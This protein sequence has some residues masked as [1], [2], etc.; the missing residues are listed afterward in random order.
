LA[1]DPSGFLS[2]EQD[3][4]TAI[5]VENLEAFPVDVN[6]ASREQLL[7]V[8]GVGPTSAQR[9]LENRRQHKIDT[10]HDLQAMGVVRTRAWPFLA[11]P[12]QRPPPGKQL[13]LELFGEAAREKQRR[14]LQPAAASAATSPAPASPAG[15]G[16][17]SAPCGAGGSCL[18]CSMY[19]VPGH[20]GSE[21]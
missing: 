20:P 17:A 21:R 11:F 14:Q 18:G 12:G 19:G 2:L 6:A 10:W 9:I 7:R 13:R 5:A 4:K 16:P 1:F 8:P 3:P 15:S